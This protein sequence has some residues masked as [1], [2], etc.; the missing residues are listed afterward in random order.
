MVDFNRGGTIRITPDV[1]ADI[2]NEMMERMIF[3]L[4]TKYP[5]IKADYDKGSGDLVFITRSEGEAVC[6]LPSGIIAKSMDDNTGGMS[7]KKIRRGIGR[8]INTAD[9]LIQESLKT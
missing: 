5:N 3:L 7:I 9:E 8:V 1:L 6:R 4:F 2:A